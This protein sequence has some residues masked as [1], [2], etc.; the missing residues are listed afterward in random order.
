MSNPENNEKPNPEQT[1]SFAD[2][3]SQYEQSHQRRSD[4]GVRQ[5]EA[6]VI[7]VSP[8]FVFFD[9]GYKTEG[10]LPITAFE[11]TPPKPGEKVSVTVR[12]RNQEGYYELS[13]FK[14][15][16]PTDWTSLERAFAEKSTI[17][18]TVTGIVKGGLTV[19]VGVRAFLP[20][21][22]SGTREA[23][24]MEKLV[25]QEIRC[26]I[27]ELDTTDEDVVVD[28]R[29]VLEEEERAGKERRYS[30]LQEGDIVKGTVRSL[31]DYGAFVDIGGVDGLLHVSDIS[32]SRIKSP[33]DVLSVGQE[34]EAR[35]LRIDRDKQRISL[36]LKQLQPVPWDTAADKYKTGERLRGTVS[37]TTDF[38]AFVELE[39]GIEGLIHISELS[40]SK[41]RVLNPLEIVKP[42][43]TVEA[44][45]LSISPTERR[46]SLGLKQALGD[47]W[48]EIG[49]RF[50]AGAV[51]EGPVA[52]ITKFGA[53][54]QLAEGV[55][56][57]IHVSEISAEKRI[58]HPQDVL[59]LGQMVRA[60]VLSIDTERRLMRLS[61]K[62]L[63]P[64]SLDEYIAE[65]KIGDVVT[66]RL[67]DTSGQV[68]V[69]LGE[70]IQAVCRGD[71]QPATVDETKEQSAGKADLSS[72]G[73]MLQARWKGGAATKVDV[74]PEPLR[75]GQV[76]SFQI[77]KLDPENKVIEVERAG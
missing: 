56:G 43:E 70:G 14:V 62:Q 30:E 42:G 12:G 7:S 17:A 20:A 28:R 32:L 60:Q 25:G 19:D 41:K 23:A 71:V 72:L 47:P 50:A 61:M 76:R 38:G 45:V 33:A 55:E 40:W 13:R 6:T 24:E 65:H 44:V 21:S 5:I 75:T 66:G 35:V 52:S 63:V 68:R 18:G 77:T 1:E 59:K 8:E 9:I 16:Q 10:V 2:M 51:I 48:A 49:K 58:N 3:L 36:G 67:I 54:V 34:I 53:F 64:T 11:G 22:R 73:A 39:P 29:A 4:N 27:T 15:A 37:R 74:K 69:E 57:M 31:M 26:R 46:I